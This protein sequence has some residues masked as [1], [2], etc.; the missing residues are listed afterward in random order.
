MM[1]TLYAAVVAEARANL[2]FALNGDRL[3]QVVS[4]TMLPATVVGCVTLR[5]TARRLGLT[6]LTPEE[7]DTAMAVTR[8][9]TAAE[10]QALGFRALARD[11][12]AWAARAMRPGV[13]AAQV[14]REVHGE[15]RHQ[16]HPSN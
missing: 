15:P 1:E 2:A 3:H 5:R 12:R 11:P 9:L 13:R 14:V 16:S 4:L 6:G 10:G 7:F 8:S